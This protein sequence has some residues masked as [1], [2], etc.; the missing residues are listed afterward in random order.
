MGISWIT[1]FNNG[2]WC[3]MMVAS[4]I[5]SDCCVVFHCLLGLLDGWMV[6][7][8]GLVRWLFVECISDRAVCPASTPNELISLDRPLRTIGHQ[9]SS[10]ARIHQKPLWTV[11]NHYRINHAQPLCITPNSHYSW[12]ISVKH[13]TWVGFACRGGIDLN[14]Q[15]SMITRTIN[16]RPVWPSKGIPKRYPTLM[17]TV[18]NGEPSDEDPA[19]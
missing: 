11:L 10:L 9:Y 12:L 7:C 13:E 16:T 4:N 15:I 2:F 17:A 18:L 14:R 6:G 8:D 1:M 19:V 5:Q 3:S